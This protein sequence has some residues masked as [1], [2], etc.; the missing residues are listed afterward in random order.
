MEAEGSRAPVCPQGTIY[1]GG[2]ACAAAEVVV[3]VQR[4]C[5]CVGGHCL[6]QGRDEGAWPGSGRREA[7]DGTVGSSGSTASRMQYLVPGFNSDT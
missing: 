4:Y 5:V 2:Q 1:W 6:V 7:D 3:V